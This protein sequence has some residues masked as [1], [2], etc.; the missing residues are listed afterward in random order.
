MKYTIII[1][2]LLLLLVTLTSATDVTVYIDA[3]SSNYNA[4][5]GAT[6]DT[7]CPDLITAIQAFETAN[8]TLVDTLTLQLL[9]NLQVTN[10]SNIYLD[11]I[12]ITINGPAVIDFNK[13]GH[14]IIVQQTSTSVSCYITLNNLVLQNAMT[15]ADGSFIQVDFTPTAVSPIITVVTNNCTFQNAWSQGKGGAISFHGV[16][17]NLATLTIENCQFNNVSAYFTGSAIF[18]QTATV[19]V[20]GSVFSNLISTGGLINMGDC[21]LLI[22]S[23]NFSATTVLDGTLISVGTGNVVQV[24]HSHFTDIVFTLPSY[25]S[26]FGSAIFW[27]YN[28]TLDVDSSFF[29]N[30]VNATAIKADA[31]SNATLSNSVI[32]GSV[33]AQTGGAV[34]AG[35]ST[36][37]AISN[38]KINAN[39]AKFGGAIYAFST[40][41][42]ITNSSFIDNWGLVNNETIYAFGTQLIIANSTFSVPTNGT[43]IL[44]GGN[45]DIFLNGVT[46]D[47]IAPV[48]CFETS[49]HLS[50]DSVAKSCQ[51]HTS[52][53][54]KKPNIGLIV[55]V[56]VGAVAGLA[57][58][59]LIIYIVYKRRQNAKKMS[60]GYY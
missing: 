37:F 31:Y 48:E 39:N 30:T 53:P 8:N 27:S 56:A 41:V 36:N 57:L 22:N 6:A 59:V 38:C 60:G 14:F 49:C 55:G 51:P 58:I 13:T 9:S 3:A 33:G 24:S 42:T 40:T 32:S 12:N 54:S 15:Y 1:T 16:N 18:A 17:T 20:N 46:T 5:C 52:T 43:A 44:C 34:S 35:P 50:G 47:Q 19:V 21:Q 4:S 26:S 10:N 29:Y 7:A 2:T 45:S 28:S 23:T 25:P 11:N